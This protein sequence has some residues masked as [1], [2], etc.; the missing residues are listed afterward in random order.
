MRN[1]SNHIFLIYNANDEK[2]WQGG[3]PETS[4]PGMILVIKDTM[5]GW[6]QSTKRVYSM[7]RKIG[8]DA[9]RVLK[10]TYVDHV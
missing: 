1:H 10:K 3:F 2:P 6:R 5:I 9:A 4:I 7:G 8:C